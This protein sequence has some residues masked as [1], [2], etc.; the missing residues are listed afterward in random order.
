[1]AG[2]VLWF[3]TALDSTQPLQFAISAPTECAPIRRRTLPFGGTLSEFEAVVQE[4][5]AVALRIES[6]E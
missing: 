1:M 3:K 5:K 6:V 4:K 2:L